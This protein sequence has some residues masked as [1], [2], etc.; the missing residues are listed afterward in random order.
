MKKLHGRVCVWMELNINEH[1]MRE[2][3]TSIYC[4]VEIIPQAG[5]WAGWLA[6]K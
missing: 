4:K 1:I 5:T 6:G 3:M 2:I